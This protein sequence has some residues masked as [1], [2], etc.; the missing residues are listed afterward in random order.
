MS[1]FISWS[2]RNSHSHKMAMLLKEWLPKVLQKLECFLS[3]HDIEAGAAWIK[4]LFEQLEQ[5]NVGVIC[6]T[7][8]T[9]NKPWILFEAGALAK[10]IEASRLCP[11]LIGLNPSDV[12]F[13]LAAFQLKTIAREDIRSL[14]AMINKSREG[15]SLTDA[16]LTEVFDLRWPQFEKTLNSIVREVEQDSTVTPSRSDSDILTEIL[17]LTRG[18][19]SQ[20]APTTEA[21][22]PN[23]LRDPEHHFLANSAQAARIWH[24]VLDQTAIRRKLIIGWL[25]KATSVDYNEQK[26]LFEISFSAEDKSVYE[27]VK[28]PR[29]TEFVQRLVNEI[30]SNAK[31]QW[32]YI[33]F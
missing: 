1:V 8:S 31:L 19:A 16:E 14:L 20:T 24:H 5:S 28:I 17:A 15:A 18:I 27:S 12:E 26:G 30:E 29:I 2:G 3:S 21:R 7:R 33:P 22:T 32:D 23:R 11:L 25:E 6:L 13:P 9:L 10:K 4:V